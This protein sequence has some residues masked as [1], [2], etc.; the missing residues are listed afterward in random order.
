MD[1]YEIGDELLIALMGN[2]GEDCGCK[3]HRQ[4]RGDGGEGEPGEG[5]GGA[6]SDKEHKDGKSQSPSKNKQQEKSPGDSPDASENEGET[7]SVNESHDDSDGGEGSGG[8]AEDGA[9]EGGVQG[10]S[11]DDPTQGDSQNGSNHDNQSS[12]SS[13]GIGDGDS[14]NDSQDDSQSD[15]DSDGTSGSGDGE[16]EEGENPESEKADGNGSDPDEQESQDEGTDEHSDKSSEKEQEQEPQQPANQKQS[17]KRKPKMSNPL[18]L[19]NK[20]LKQ[21]MRP[22]SGKLTQKDRGKLEKREEANRNRSNHWEQYEQELDRLAKAGDGVYHQT[23]GGGG[24]KGSGVFQDL[25]LD[26]REIEFIAS[27]IMDD[28][29]CPAGVCL[30]DKLTKEAY[31]S[32]KSIILADLITKTV[33]NTVGTGIY[34]SPRIDPRKLIKGLLSKHL[35]LEAIGREE[36]ER[37]R[38]MIICDVSG[39]TSELCN[40][41][42]AAAYRVMD[43]D[44]RVVVLF[45]SNEHIHKIIGHGVDAHTEEIAQ[46]INKLLGNMN[47]APAGEP[48][49]MDAHGALWRELVNYMSV[50]FVVGFHDAQGQAAFSHICE[51]GVPLVW[52][53]NSGM[54]HG[55]ASNEQYLKVV[56]DEMER[57]ERGEPRTNYMRHYD[58]PRLLEQEKGALD[59]IW[60]NRVMT[61]WPRPP[62][63]MV[64]DAGD[65]DSASKALLAYLSTGEGRIQ[66]GG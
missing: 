44:D 4:M 30:Q 56:R 25:P 22:D 38:L 10:E 35:N 26:L 20:L 50:R 51:M 65:T 5:E 31:D 34:D 57:I 15:T 14:G 32:P 49:W 11:Q 45:I 33:D 43:R 13:G 42:A 18:D 47:I 59:G 63:A 23:L 60:T 28:D 1:K 12:S 27:E 2:H 52:M 3:F 61:Q 17:N 66:Q 29:H 53:M 46:K 58:L 21:L 24:T 16:S 19:D 55:E 39:S 6:P 9:G 40:F 64:R 41:M 54:S 62:V 8:E 7:D 37:K 36:M 48:K